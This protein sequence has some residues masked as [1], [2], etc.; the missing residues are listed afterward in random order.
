MTDESRFDDIRPYRDDE[1]N[2]AMQRIAQHQSFPFLASFIYPDLSVEQAREKVCSFNSIFD[3]QYGAMAPMNRQIIDGTISDFT[4]GGVEKLDPSKRYLYVSNH[5]DI[6][7]DSCLLYYALYW[8]GHE[9]GEITFGSNLMQGQLLVDIGKSNKMFRV[10]RGGTPREMYA[11]SVHLSEYIRYA[12]T[13]KRQ[14]VW[15]AQRNGRTKDG[16][17][18]TDVGEIKMFSMSGPKDRVDNLAQLSIVPVSVSYEW[19]SCDILKALELYATRDG[20][21]Y[22][23]KQGEDLNSILTGISQDKGRVHFQIC[24]PI[25]RADLES[26]SDEPGA[27]FYRSV[28]ALIDSRIC[29][30]Y[31]LFPNAYIAHD[32]KNGTRSDRYS[33][34]E[35]DAFVKHMAELDRYS[36]DPLLKDIFLGIY[37]NP[38]DNNI[39]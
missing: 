18:R 34:L 14:S 5:R 1:I 6:V 3:Y 9:T 32:L 16:I 8:H 30:A 12:L 36:H 37:C 7:L 20:Q 15:I 22:V 4:I 38:I 29:S 23:K 19:E 35:Y 28:A 25:T 2:A 39:I 10:E 33:Q 24:D 31:R 11:S 27:Q 17:D 26:K 13:E 21:P